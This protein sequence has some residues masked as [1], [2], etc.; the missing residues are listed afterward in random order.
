MAL[1]QCIILVTAIAVAIVPVILIAA[2]RRSKVR[3]DDYDREVSLVA[4]DLLE[5]D[6]E[7]LRPLTLDERKRRLAHLLQSVKAGIELNEHP[8][9][10]GADVFRAAR[11]PGH[12]G[13]VANRRDSRYE[14]GRSMRWVKIKN[15][16]S[17]AAKRLEDG[18]SDHTSSGA[19]R[20]S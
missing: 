19:Y 3:V 2:N 17:A 12:E 8:K 4:F 6:G 16:D 14:S 7:D 13:I 1:E 9:G 15:P 20:R 5:K 11:S 18:V 10:D